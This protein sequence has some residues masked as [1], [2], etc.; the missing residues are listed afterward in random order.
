MKKFLRSKS[1]YIFERILIFRKLSKSEILLF[2]GFLAF[3]AHSFQSEYSK[4]EAQHALNMLI[5]HNVHNK[6][7]LYS[8]RAVS[9]EECQIFKIKT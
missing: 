2:C 9:L 1:A 7:L 4:K 5:C 6:G 3:P 8:F